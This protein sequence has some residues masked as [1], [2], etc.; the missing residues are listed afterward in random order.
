M[1]CCTN[2]GCNWNHTTASGDLAYSTYTNGAALPTSSGNGC[3][4]N[5]LSAHA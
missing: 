5:A 2:D 1:D 4:T 3:G